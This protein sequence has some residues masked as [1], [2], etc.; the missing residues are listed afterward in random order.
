MARGEDASMRAALACADALSSFHS[1]AF[2]DCC[3]VLAPLLDAEECKWVHVLGNHAIAS[4]LVSAPAGEGE[5][6]AQSV[7]VRQLH[8]AQQ[9]AEAK[10]ASCAPEEKAYLEQAILYAWYNRCVLLYEQRCVEEVTALLEEKILPWLAGSAAISK[11][12]DPVGIVSLSACLLLLDSYLLHTMRAESALPEHAAAVAK[13]LESAYL[14]LVLEWSKARAAGGNTSTPGTGAQ[15]T[16]STGAATSGGGSGKVRGTFRGGRQHHALLEHFPYLLH[17]YKAKIALY[18]RV[19]RNP[20]KEIRQAM[21]VGQ[22]N[23]ASVFLKANMEY[24]RNNHSKALRLFEALKISQHDNDPLLCLIYYNNL[25][26]IYARMHRVHAT[27]FYAAAALHEAHLI[28][29]ASLRLRSVR[30]RNRAAEVLYNNALAQLLRGDAV[31]AYKCFMKC[32]PEFMTNPVAW[33]RT[34]ECIVGMIASSSHKA[35]L[36]DPWSRTSPSLALPECGGDGGTAPSVEFAIVCMRNCLLLWREH[37]PMAFQSSPSASPTAGAPASPS[38]PATPPASSAAASSSPSA[39]AQQAALLYLAYLGLYAGDPQLVISSCSELQLMKNVA[40][41]YIYLSH[42]YNTEALCMLGHYSEAIRQ[43][44]PALLNDESALHLSA[45]VSASPYGVPFSESSRYFLFH[46]LVVC[47]VRNA[48]YD[49]AE[50]TLSKAVVTC[51]PA[52]E[53]YLLSLSAF[54]HLKQGRTRQALSILQSGRR[55]ILAHAES[56]HTE[57][58]AVYTSGGGGGAQ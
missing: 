31:V 47:H 14:P 29:T 7:A 9:R 21:S 22:Q 10:L 17:D 52:C 36:G 46:N 35:A 13:L 2:K 11:T 58:S 18:G 56:S 34:G 3:A 39:T 37:S 57:G 48:N 32:L 8:A 41:C 12:L 19:Q 55:A 54:V 38:S 5:E 26:C 53:H 33:L 6:S 1:N 44:S 24:T 23:P 30:C 15:S 40:K 49:M 4:Y 28:Y 43:L 27:A 50:H 25:S 16:A 42:I 20:K 51:P 45:S